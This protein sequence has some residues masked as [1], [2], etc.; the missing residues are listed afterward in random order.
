MSSLRLEEAAERGQLVEH[1][2]VSFGGIGVLSLEHSVPVALIVGTC[3]SAI[4]RLRQANS[5][6][7]LTDTPTCRAYKYKLILSVTR[8]EN[9]VATGIRCNGRECSVV[10]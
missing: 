7:A 8:Y 3:V 6:P 5:P 9:A 2:T 10:P 4:A 1:L